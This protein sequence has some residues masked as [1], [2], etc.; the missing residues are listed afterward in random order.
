MILLIS[1]RSELALNLVSFEKGSFGS[2]FFMKYLRNIK[3]LDATCK[4]IAI[5]DD[6]I[7]Y[8]DRGDY[9]DVREHQEERLNFQRILTFNS[10]KDLTDW[11]GKMDL[12]LFD[13]KYKLLM[14]SPC[15]VTTNVI[16]EIKNRND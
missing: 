3:D 6:S 7:I 4:Y 11:M 12:N 9:G 15:K 16:I 10:D 2:F 13:K 14:V 8:T 1:P 5:Y